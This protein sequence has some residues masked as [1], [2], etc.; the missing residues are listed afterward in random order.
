LEHIWV[1]YPGEKRYPVADRVTAIPLTELVG[2]G[3]ALWSQWNY[4]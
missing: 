3:P 1:V 2:S 4:R